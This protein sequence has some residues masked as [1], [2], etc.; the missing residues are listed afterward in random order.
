MTCAVVP[1]IPTNFVVRNPSTVYVRCE[2]RASL[3][4][5]DYPIIMHRGWGRQ[6]YVARG[7]HFS[8]SP[9]ISSNHI[10][11]NPQILDKGWPNEGLCLKD[12]AKILETQKPLMK[13]PVP[14][15]GLTTLS[16]LISIC[17]PAI[18]TTPDPVMLYSF[19]FECLKFLTCITL[20]KPRR[21]TNTAAMT[22]F[23]N[24]LKRVRRVKSPTVSDIHTRPLNIVTKQ[25]LARFYTTIESLKLALK[26]TNIRFTSFDL[27]NAQASF[28]GTCCLEINCPVGVLTIHFSGPLSKASNLY[29]LPASAVRQQRRV[30]T[31]PFCSNK[32][33]AV[34]FNFI[35][36]AG[37]ILKISRH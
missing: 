21:K 9:L 22:I 1:E 26:F 8:N 12:K 10:I 13:P 24:T 14:L 19:G 28:K 32:L 3:N 17:A 29:T 15:A 27:E 2:T 23:S 6:K 25:E 4:Q 31:I 34:A 35:A 37:S 7:T 16:L 5:R 11:I 18:S 33:D 30:G 20:L 36:V